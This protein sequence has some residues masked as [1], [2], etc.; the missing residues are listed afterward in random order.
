MLK[1]SDFKMPSL[2][3]QDGVLICLVPKLMSLAL[4]TIF[5]P[6]ATLEQEKREGETKSIHD[7]L[8]L[9]QA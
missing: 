8:M 6:E 3:A 7:Y 5:F 1:I 2:F 4:W 9:Y